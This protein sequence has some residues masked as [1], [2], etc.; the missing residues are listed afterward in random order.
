MKAGDVIEDAAELTVKAGV[1]SA[2]Q[3]QS[4]KIVIVAIAGAILALILGAAFY[5]F[6]IRPENLAADA[7]KSHGGEV[8]AQHGTIAATKALAIV[9]D[10][11]QQHAATDAATERNDHAIKQAADAATPVPGVAGALHDALCL[12]AAYQHEPD[13]VAL[14]GAPGRDASAR[15]DAGGDA[16]GQ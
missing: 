10:T 12:R 4:A 8:V 7:A 2:P 14:S 1:A 5:W 11:R 6:F 3:I 16:P 15:P 13:C 9:D